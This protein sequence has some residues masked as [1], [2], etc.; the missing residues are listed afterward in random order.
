MG[1]KN[2]R[3]GISRRSF[4]LGSGLAAATA[5]SAG[6]IGC[7]PKQAAETNGAGNAGPDAGANAQ[8]AQGGNVYQS[9][10]AQLNVQDYDYR[11]NSGDLSHVLS[12]WKLGNMEFSN[13]IV[14]SAAGSNYENGGWDAFVEYYRRLAAGGTEMIWV[15]NF[16]HIFLPYKN[17]INGNIDEFTDEQ[18]KQLTDTIHAEGAKCGTQTDIMGSAFYTMVVGRGGHDASLFTLDE[19]DFMV[20]CYVA[21]AKKFKAWGFDAWELNCAG[22]NQTQWFFSRSRNHRDDEYG[23]QTFENRVRFIG[24]IIEAVRAEV[25]ED[26]P[27]QVLLDAINENDLNIGENAEFNTVEDN[28]EIA[29]ELEKAGVSSLHV[30]LGPQEQHATQ[31]LGDLYFDTRGGIGST[32]FGGQFDFS[33]HFQG[34]LV[35]NH[36]GCGLMLNLSKMFTEAV[37]IPVGTVTYLDPAHAPD[38]IDKAIADGMVDFLMINRPLTVDNQYVN[39]LKEGRIDEIR[40]CTR[41]CHCWNDTVKGDPYTTEGFG[42]QCYCCRI[43]PIRDNVGQEEKG[44]P[45]WFDPPE[46]D[47][48]KNVMV[49]GAGPAGMEAAR[50]AAERGYAVTLYDRK[51]STGGLLSFAAAIKG[52][53]QNLEDYSSWSRADLERKGVNIVTGQE[54]DAAFI[55][56]QA[57]DVVVLALGGKRD[58]LGIEGDDATNIISIDDIVNK[59]DQIGQNVTIVGGNLQA[60]DVAAYLMEQGKHVSIVTPESAS[61]LAKGQSIWCKRFALPILYAHGMK[62]WQESELASAGG[63]TATVKTSTGTETPYACDTVVEAMDMLPN[64]DLLD[65]LDGI[66]AYAVGDCDEPY[67]IEYAV[68]AGN[69]VARAI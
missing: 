55:K 50:I 64:K 23:S 12:P 35:A 59:A 4:L 54:V 17:T 66:E 11:Q 40:P 24:R 43:D 69:F 9:I 41:C 56:E 19:I 61:M 62:V 48:E 13:R 34:K 67:N 58:T 33:R 57:P 63:G 37:S 3:A 26:F 16:C 20:D 45:G 44:M 22:N 39:K 28:I 2:A 38:F 14:K 15:E 65:E 32:S 31:F 52:P 30:R 29:K 5:A 1:Q 47:G 6:L 49:V 36:D 60:I 18:V 7:A 27:I 10:A 21:A 51:S 53:H 68:R 8:S 25:G 42:G 46:G